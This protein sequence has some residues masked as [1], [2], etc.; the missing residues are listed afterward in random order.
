LQVSRI[1]HRFG[2]GP[3]PGEFQQALKNG[4][5]KSRSLVLGV[6]QES[7]PNV[8]M[9]D[10]SLPDL[11]KRP[12]PNSP[13]LAEFNNN[14]RSQSEVL[15]LWWLDKMVL[16]EANFL[17]KMTWFWHGHWATSIEKVAYPLPMY[18]QNVT[19]RTHAL[20]S[21]NAMAKAM[22]QDVALQFWLDGQ[23]NTVK[24]P[25]ENLG[26][27]LM[28]L[29]ILGVNRYT[30]DDVKS[31]ARALTGYQLN[32]SSGTLFFNRDRFDY[33][34]ITLLGTTTYFNAPSVTEFLVARDDCAT[35]IAERIWYRFFSS[36]ES[37]PASFR[38]SIKKSFVERNINS[39]MKAAI[40]DP[41]MSDPKYVMAK[42]PVEWFVGACRALELRPSALQTPVRLKSLLNKL[43]QL[44][45]APP[46]VGGWPAGQAWLTSASAQYRVEF[47]NWL[48]EQSSL[49]LINQSPIEKRVQLIADWLG[50]VGWSDR[51]KIALSDSVTQP[52]TLA[53]IALCSPEYVISA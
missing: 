29:F 39:A 12:A 42:S 38:S 36:T 11:G 48:I 25:N 8:S 37:M 4:V 17:E 13:A 51:T 16:S 6:G 53:M 26:R 18:K 32:L 49:R 31:I 9:A 3:R 5:S 33:S 7:V 15:L 27:E 10:L 24:K 23:E 52:P 1:F 21:F 34:Q 2:F 41:V 44:P 19:L 46:S 45:F 28:E 40:E 47:A 20:G 43:G 50:V 30:E 22:V 14:L 35:F